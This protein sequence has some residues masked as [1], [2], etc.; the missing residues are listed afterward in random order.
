M[1]LENH[2]EELKKAI[3]SLKDSALYLLL[4]MSKPKDLF[5]IENISENLVHNNPESFSAPVVNI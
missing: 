2:P 1:I 5:I 4:N 3:E